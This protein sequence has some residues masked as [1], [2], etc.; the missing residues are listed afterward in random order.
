MIR[1]LLLLGVAAVVTPTA[2]PA[3]TAAPGATPTPTVTPT[4]R[5]AP[6]EIYGTRLPAG[7]SHNA[8]PTAT[9][10]PALSALGS[11]AARTKLRSTVV[12]DRPDSGG[13]ELVTDET[14]ASVAIIRRF[15]ESAVRTAHLTKYA[16]ENNWE[17]KDAAWFGSMRQACVDLDMIRGE[18]GQ[19]QVPARYEGQVH[20]WR[21]VLDAT[22]R[23]YR[24]VLQAAETRDKS[25]AASA[26][27]LVQEA[28]SAIR[29]MPAADGQILAPVE[30]PQGRP[31]TD[32]PY[33]GDEE[34]K[35]RCA[36]E[37][38]SDFSMQTYCVEQQ[39]KARA[40]IA[41]RAPGNVPDSVFEQIRTKCSA[42]WPNS[43]QMQD[44]CEEQQIGAWR[45]LNENP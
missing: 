3:P 39:Q 38:P 31:S 2:T 23:A 13:G 30:K 43:L 12:T 29:R 35:A 6:S 21:G 18:L 24:L 45:E 17:V 25:L 4:R 26:T 20:A 40:S 9:P 19:V 28:T 15:L 16:E 37:W 27:K 34:I 33:R 44:Y 41:N 10:T 7:F 32:Q 11:F 5:P 14:E 22:V 36:H 8:R 42:D 1:T